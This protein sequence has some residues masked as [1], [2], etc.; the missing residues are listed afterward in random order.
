MTRWEH[1]RVQTEAGVLEWFDNVDF[2]P[3]KRHRPH[4]VDLGNVGVADI[5]RCARIEFD[6][7]WR[8]LQ[9]RRPFVA[10]LHFDT[11]GAITWVLDN[12]H[13]RRLFG[14]LREW[15]VESDSWMDD[16]ATSV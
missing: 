7:D 5:T 6:G 11:E 15:Y 14:I 1:H 13:S 4:W 16:A 3:G 12:T 10:R 8:A 9:P 2:E